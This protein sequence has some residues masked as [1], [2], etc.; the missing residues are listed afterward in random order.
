MK[1]IK[2]LILLAFVCLGLFSVESN[3]QDSR[4]IKSYSSNTPNKYENEKFSFNDVRYF[5]DSSREGFETL[6]YQL[7]EEMLPDFTAEELFFFCLDHPKLRGS[8]KPD[9]ESV[10]SFNGFKEIVNRHDFLETLKKHTTQYL[11]D[12]IEFQ[13]RERIGYTS[14]EEMKKVLLF[15]NGFIFFLSQPFIKSMDKDLK[16]DLKKTLSQIAEDIKKRAGG[17]YYPF[18]ER[19]FH[20]DEIQRWLLSKYNQTPFEFVTNETL[21]LPY[22]QRFRYKNGTFLFPDMR[23]DGSLSSKDYEQKKDAINSLPYQLPPELLSQLTTE[24]L[25]YYYA[26]HPCFKTHTPELVANFNG[27]VELVSRKDVLE[28]AGKIVANHASTYN[29]KLDSQI[30]KFFFSKS[31][32]EKLNIS[33]KIELLKTIKTYFILIEYQSY[34]PLYNFFLQCYPD[35]KQEW[36]KYFY[37]IVALSRSNVILFD[38]N[39]QEAVQKRIESES[40]RKRKE[41]ELKIIEFVDELINEL[42]FEKNENK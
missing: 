31:L 27:Y 3:D 33:Q 12:A 38:D 20:Y 15:D 6:P 2:I 24:E 40:E 28:K 30:M 16:N 7:P 13:K 9:F 37:G 25:L 21:R 18:V 4:Y 29:S 17:Y 10:L 32:W 5:I 14:I 19:A 36:S 39:S 22:L 23:Y 41:R 26:D 34:L 35:R 1:K 42:E 8:S 11:I